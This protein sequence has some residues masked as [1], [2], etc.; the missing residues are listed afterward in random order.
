MTTLTIKNIVTRLTDQPYSLWA[1]HAR[2]ES[3]LSSSRV[4]IEK[5]R[6]KDSAP[7][8]SAEKGAHQHVG[9]YISCDVCGR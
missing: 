2:Y 3:A 6:K 4:L 8:T 5:K 1:I 7:T 9:Y